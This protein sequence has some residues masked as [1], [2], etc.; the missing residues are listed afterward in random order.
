M[1]YTACKTLRVTTNANVCVMGH[2]FLLSSTVGQQEQRQHTNQLAQRRFVWRGRRQRLSR[3]RST[4]AMVA[5]VMMSMVRPVEGVA[6]KLFA[7]SRESGVG[8]VARGER[9]RVAT[10]TFR[11]M[12][13]AAVYFSVSLL[14]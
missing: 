8:G 7:D 1:V 4:A 12:I 11:G 2:V 3:W 13:Y 5:A 10:V 6:V 14:P 9:R